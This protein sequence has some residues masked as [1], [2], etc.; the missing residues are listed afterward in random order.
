M[1]DVVTNTVEVPEVIEVIKPETPTR[2]D[3]KA[4]GWTKE[5]MDSAEKHGLIS[6]PKE[7]VKE[8]PKVED[9]EK[10]K[11]PVAEDKKEPVK[12]EEPKQ[13]DFKRSSIPE[14]DL[15]AE[16]E[17][18][19]AEILPPGNSLRGVY[20][21]MKNERTA[22]QNMQAQLEK[23]RMARI[24]L[25]AKLRGMQSNLFE[26]DGE[27]DPEDRPLTIRALRELQIKEQ[28][29]ALKRDQEV[30]SRAQAVMEAQVAQEEYAKQLYP[31]FNEVVVNAQ[32]V[33]KNM[34]IIDEPWKRAKA[35]KLFKELKEA[36]AN[37]DTIGL[38][39]YNAAMIGYEIGLLHPSHGKKSEQN[40]EV[41]RPEPK[42]N[43]GL[44][45]EQMKRIEE[46]TQRRASSATVSGGSGR[47]TVSA[48]SVTLADI[49]KMDSRQRLS[50]REKY[51]DHYAKLLRG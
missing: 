24:E 9:N 22:R 15:T 1:S 27:G 44:T 25:E 41:L 8:D 26:D 21:R 17:K 37:A 7:V 4:K 39:D 11:D 49:N 45:P 42:V 18:A 10:V 33:I 30:H 50:F 35:V 28:E 23:E 36:A 48:D 6:K 51:P 19:L 32:E 2:E 38:D 20:F 12:K 43:G 40:G 31:D 34:G 13:P 47:R 5:E 29:A 3:V 16:Q 14:Y 46:N